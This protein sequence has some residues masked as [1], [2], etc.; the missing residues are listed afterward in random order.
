ME[1]KNKKK[2]FAIIGGSVL[3]FV[4][5]IALSVSITLAYF[6]GTASGT[7]TITMGGSV[8]VDSALTMVG[9]M[10]D[11]VPGQSVAIS[12]STSVTSSSQ[13]YAAAIMLVKVSGDSSITGGANLEASGWNKITA[14]ATKEA[15]ETDEVYEI[16]VHGTESA[17]TVINAKKDAPVALAFTGTFTADP[18]WGNGVAD[19]SMS[20]EFKLV[21][22]QNGTDAS[23]D[24][25]EPAQPK[26]ASTK[27]FT[28][29]DDIFQS[30]L[31][32]GWTISTVA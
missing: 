25:G 17:L 31:G 1:K 14:T 15:G 7:A 12:A 29:L 26:T 10:D 9:T 8:A 30:V 18:Q 2:L 28:A 6:G 4:L 32:E 5:T 27:A 16:Y 23:L 11:V 19:K 13:Q 21:V 24:D 22:A 3:A 20:I